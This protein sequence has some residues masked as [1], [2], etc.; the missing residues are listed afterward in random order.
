[1]LIGSWL[2]SGLLSQFSWWV[3]IIVFAS[4]FGVSLD[5]ALGGA[6]DC[7]CFGPVSIP[8]TWV[9]LFDGAAIL[10]LWATERTRF[11]PPRFIRTRAVAFAGLAAGW[12]PGNRARKFAASVD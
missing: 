3:A 6:N 12:V 9:T 4:L 2:V 10:A 5:K 11:R 8:P 1:M 7:G